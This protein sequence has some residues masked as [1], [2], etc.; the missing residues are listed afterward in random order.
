MNNSQGSDLAPRLTEKECPSGKSKRWE[1]MVDRYLGASDLVCETAVKAAHGLRTNV[2]EEDFLDMKKSFV[3]KVTIC[4]IIV[5]LCLLLVSCQSSGGRLPLPPQ[6]AMGMHSDNRID[7][8]YV[9]RDTA[10]IVPRTPESNSGSIFAETQR[11]LNLFGE[12]IP[13]QPGEFITVQIP[14]ELQFKASSGQDSKDSK[15]KAS[16]GNPQ[17]GDAQAA[18]ENSIIGALQTDIAT[19]A[20]FN[21][22]NATPLTSIKM[23]I[24]GIDGSTVYLRGSKS[25][26]G[27]AQGPQSQ[28]D[29]ANIILTASIPVAAVRGRTVAATDL[30]QIEITRL[31]G[32][33]PGIY[34]TDGWDSFVSRQLSGYSPDL[35]PDLD[36]LREF[37]SNLAL[38]QRNLNERFKALKQE[39][40]RYKGEKSRAAKL[41][42]ARE[43]PSGSGA[44]PSNTGGTSNGSPQTQEAQKPAEAADLGNNPEEAGRR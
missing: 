3:L 4:G 1:L 29:E 42:T 43:S 15:S 9:R 44:T 38:Q 27:S 21:S 37:E 2:Q 16:S 35:G 36:R 23:E 13:T 18:A 10:R 6:G 26:R 8:L 31:E 28:G 40:Q 32:G 7:P 17:S 19:L 30:S 5:T 11:P 12:D 20:S 34:R 41:S 39:Q 33:R 25:Y 24:I 22:I 14:P